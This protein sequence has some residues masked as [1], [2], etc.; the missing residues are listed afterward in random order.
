[1]RTPSIKTLMARQVMGSFIASVLAS[2]S[3]SSLL[4]MRYLVT[5]MYRE[6]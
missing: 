1:M 3:C 6:Y 4:E 2:S 5:K